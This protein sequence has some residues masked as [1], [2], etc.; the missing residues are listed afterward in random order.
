LKLK[1]NY[2]EPTTATSAVPVGTTA[3]ATTTATKTSSTAKAAATTV[4]AMA[5]PQCQNDN[6]CSG[7]YCCNLNNNQC[8]LDPNNNI[9]DIPPTNTLKTTTST[10]AGTTT[11]TTTAT[12]TTTTSGSSATCVA[13]SS[14]LGNGNG[15]NGYCCKTSNDCLDTCVSGKVH[16]YLFIY[17]KKAVN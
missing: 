3:G 10:K 2:S 16:I 11:K 8:V 4:L 1:I 14:G 15:Y 7:I 17:K 6:D 9:C 5:G 12:K 13:G